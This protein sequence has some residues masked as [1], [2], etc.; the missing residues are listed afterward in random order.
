MR[1]KTKYA[2][3]GEL[4]IAY[5]VFGNGPVDLIFVPG[6]ISQV[7]HMW[8]EPAQA[9][10]FGRLA[11]FSRVI[12]F[13]KRGTGLS[14]RHMKTPTLEERMDD[15]LAVMDAEKIK[16]AALFG[17]S[18]GGPMCILFAATYP[19]RISALV[20]YGSWAKGSRSADYPWVLYQEQY[21]RWIAEIPRTWGDLES[22]RYWAPSAAGDEGVSQWWGKLQRLG[23]GP[24]DA[25]SGKA[26]PNS[27][28]FTES[29]NLSRR[30]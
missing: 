11:S 4:Y 16:R 14:D 22:I 12:L 23:A 7:E 2:W 15:V 3:S 20:I 5:Q 19:E 25:I 30:R 27:F 29:I 6:F 13:D 8:D 9:R 21:E 10:F 28:Y 18:E 24:G 1:P 17:V 26:I